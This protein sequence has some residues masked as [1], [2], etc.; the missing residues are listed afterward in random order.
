MFQVSIRTP[1]DG[2]ETPATPAN[3]VFTSSQTSSSSD[4]GAAMRA[5]AAAQLRI[6]EEADG[7]TL[8][9]ISISQMCFKHGRITVPPGI[10]LA[11][12]GFCAPPPPSPSGESAPVYSRT[13]PPPHYSHVRNF[14]SSLTTREY[15]HFLRGGWRD[16]PEVERWWV[17]ALGG[18]VEDQR[19][20]NV[21]GLVGVVEANGPIGLLRKGMD[22]A[23]SI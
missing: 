8:N 13:N 6:T 21:E 2:L 7:A 18:V 5:I 15:A 14:V 1:A 23:K 4:I 19:R 17:K 9:C 20:A 16:V 12:S 22:G 10:V 11:A 3:P